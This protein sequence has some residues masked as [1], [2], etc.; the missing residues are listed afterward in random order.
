[1]ENAGTIR[2]TGQTDAGSAGEQPARDN[3]LRA[4]DSRGDDRQKP[5]I[6]SSLKIALFRALKGLKKL[7]A[8]GRFYL[9]IGKASCPVSAEPIH[10]DL[11]KI[12][13][14]YV[15]YKKAIC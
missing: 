6:P 12:G 3:R 10:Y 1:M 13:D 8:E 14:H 9:L 7:P 15:H 11:K 5:V 2:W 4:T